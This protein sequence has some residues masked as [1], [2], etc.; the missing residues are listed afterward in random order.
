MEVQGFCSANNQ[1]NSQ[2]QSF[3][4]PGKSCCRIQ[5][6]RLMRLKI[7]FCLV[8]FYVC[9]TEASS[10]AFDYFWDSFH[11]ILQHIV[12][13]LLHRELVPLACPGIPI[14]HVSP[15]IIVDSRAD[16]WDGEQ[17]CQGS[18]RVDECFH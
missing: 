3:I 13:I 12:E 10:I 6:S 15:N 11:D 4:K 5:L 9:H 18:Q 8:D 17:H 7:S 1:N 2:Y 14:S 16:G